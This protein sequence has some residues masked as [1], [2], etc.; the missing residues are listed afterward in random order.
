ME[1][2]ADWLNLKVRQPVL[3]AAIVVLVVADVADVVVGSVVSAIV[4]KLV[5]CEHAAELGLA[6]EIVAAVVPLPL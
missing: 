3:S 5:V 2:E 1:S 6:F 4:E